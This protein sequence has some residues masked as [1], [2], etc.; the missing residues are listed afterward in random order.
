MAELLKEIGAYWTDRAK[1]YSQY[2]QKEFGGMQREAWREV[3][4]ENF[5]NKSAAEIKIAD[6]GCGPGFFS[7]ILAEAGYHVTAVDY[8]ESM[9]AEAKVNAG[10]LADHIEFYRMDAQKLSFADESFDVVISR[11]LTWNLEHP[12]CA[13]REWHRVLKPGGVLLNFDANWYGYLFDED[14]RKAYE[15][16][17]A[18]VKQQGDMED[19]V[20]G[21]DVDAMEQIAREVPLSKVIRPGWDEKV[22]ETI[23]FCQISSDSQIWQRVWSE[24]EKMNQAS[25]PMFMVRARKMSEDAFVLGNMAVWPDEKVSGSLVLAED[26]V[27]PATIIHGSRPGKTVL[28]TAGVHAGEYVGVQ[29]AA[30]LSATL[31]ADK[32]IGTIVIIKVVNYPAFVQR[33]GSLGL[34][35]GKN[36]NR[37]FPG[38]EDGT[39]MERLAWLMTNKVYPCVDYYI[40]LHSGDDFEELTPYVYYAGVADEEVIEKSREMAQQVD[41]PYMIGSKVASGGA[42][43]HAAYACHIPSILIERGS[44]GKW[45]PEES[46]GTRRDVRNVLCH[47]GVYD[48]ERDF[49]QY[50]PLE[51][52]DVVYQAS[53]HAGCWYP[54]KKPG[55]VFLKNDFLGVVRDL[56]GNVLETSVAVSDGVVLYQTG[57]LQV[58][59]GGPMIAYGRIENRRDNRKERVVRYWNRRSDSFMEQRL[60]ELHSPLAGRWLTEI[61]KYLP[62]GRSLKI[63]DVGC[64]AG[65][66]SILLAKEGHQMTGTDLTPSM[67]DASRIL[68]QQEGVSCEFIVMDAEKLSFADETFDVVISRNLTWTLPHVEQAY[69]EWQ[70]VLKPG[71]ILLNFDANYGRDSSADTSNLPKHHAH[72]LLG[73][74]ML[75]ENEEIKKQLP[76]SSYVR[77]AWDLETLGQLGFA[78]YT[79]DLG[80]SKRIYLEKDEF[81]NPVPLFVLCTKKE[82]STGENC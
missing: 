19:Y 18:N 52:V 62:S 70:R 4:K 17:R 41:V 77:P 22:L 1:G 23:G 6:I 55:D 39:E 5:P 37:V 3:L 76:I 49:R 71:G 66:F 21:T 51:V 7:V 13:Y 12:D 57:T 58:T 61:R 56:E 33:N 8:T 26:V 45:T 81:Y 25:T 40:D 27:L 67:I 9:L 65:F 31:R 34:S 24:E 15:E 16:D 74:E 82:R 47:L 64:G 59:E 50:Y 14:K 29:A 44:M 46:G 38:K 43:N 28:I 53:S 42:Y 60:H 78:E 68:A 75:R 11:N 2:N 73:D 69:A 20:A 35:D 54:A 32:V 36:L 79:M 80:I 72:H 10:Q 30:E 48:G 63:L